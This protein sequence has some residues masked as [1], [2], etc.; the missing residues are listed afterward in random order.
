MEVIVEGEEVNV[1]HHHVVTLISTQEEAN[2]QK[3]G[4]IKSVWA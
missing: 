1:M 3:G 4:T 2:I